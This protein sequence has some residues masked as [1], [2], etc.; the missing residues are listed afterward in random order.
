MEG[1]RSLKLLVRAVAAGRL[2]VTDY[3]PRNKQHKLRTTWLLK[4][5]EE[6]TA[7]KIIDYRHRQQCALI[8]STKISSESWES[9]QQQAINS[10]EQLRY[11]ICPWLYNKPEAAQQ[12]N[13]ESIIEAYERMWGKPGTPEHDALIEETNKFLNLTPEQQELHSLRRRMRENG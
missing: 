10:F 8:A 7:A 11:F 12:T 13:D 5:F 1:D 4:E 3:D 2:D 6:E 9:M